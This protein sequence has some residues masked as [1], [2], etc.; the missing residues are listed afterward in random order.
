MQSERIPCLHLVGL[1]STLALNEG[2]LLHHTL[3]D[4]R[5]GVF[6]RMSREVGLGVDGLN[7]GC[8]VVGWTGYSMKE[9]GWTEVVDRV[10]RVAL[11]EVCF[12]RVVM[13]DKRHYGFG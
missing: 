10:I 6:E 13:S 9:E 5:M 1:P 2:R 4:G 3:A 12:G 11:D 8:E 7:R